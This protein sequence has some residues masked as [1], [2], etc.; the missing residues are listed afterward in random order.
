MSWRDGQEEVWQF[1]DIDRSLSVGLQL[2]GDCW[3]RFGDTVGV[4]GIVDGI[5]SAH[6]DFLAAGGLG[7]LIGD[8]RLPHYAVEGVIET[9]YDAEV[10]KGIHLAVDYQFVAN[11]AY[12]SDRG[13]VNI[14]SARAFTFSSSAGLFDG[15]WQNTV[16][17]ERTT[18]RR[19]DFTSIRFQFARVAQF[20]TQRSRVWT[21]SVSLFLLAVIGVVDYETGVERSWLVFYLLPVALGT[22]FV[23]W[24]FACDPLRLERNSVDRGRYRSGR[25][26]LRARLFQSGMRAL[27]SVFSSSSCGCCIVF[28]RCSTNWKTGYNKLLRRCVRK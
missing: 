2:K 11:P 13:P 5:S 1:T 8:G 12:N 27:P 10:M 17:R 6:R 22:W 19:H 18:L 3:R 14:F 4:A 20:L 23:G 16:N 25:C 24:G 15:S 21:M 9:Y 7:P 28:T 26:L